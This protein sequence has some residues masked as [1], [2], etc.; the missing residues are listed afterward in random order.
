M[1]MSDVSSRPVLRIWIVSI[2]LLT[3]M[4]FEDLIGRDV[5]ERKGGKETY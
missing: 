5:D 3:L 1:E 4:L 2:R